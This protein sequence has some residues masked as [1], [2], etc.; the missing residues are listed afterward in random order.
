MQQRIRENLDEF[1]VYAGDNLEYEFINPF[2]GKDSKVAE[3]L[4]SELYEKGLKPSNIVARDKEG[5]S[6]EKIV[7]RARSLSATLRSLLT[8]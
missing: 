4:V 6:S 1:K 8:C 5:G 7:I 3:E 2:E